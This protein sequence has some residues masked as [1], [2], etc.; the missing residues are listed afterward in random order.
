MVIEQAQKIAAPRA[1]CLTRARR[2]A[3][4]GIYRF[5]QDSRSVYD[6]L[7]QS[8]FGSGPFRFAD[9]SANAEISAAIVFVTPIISK[10]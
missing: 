9:N 3:R 8:I 10:S 2:E 5:I 7:C 6:L 1:N 4:E